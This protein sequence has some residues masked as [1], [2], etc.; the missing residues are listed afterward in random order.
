MS[1]LKQGQKPTYWRSLAELEDTPELREYV[2][3]EFATPLEELPPGSPGRRRFLQI[4]GASLALAGATG[5]RWQE[6]KLMPLSRRPEGRIPGEPERYATATELAGVAVGIVATSYEGRPIKLE[7]N[8]AHPANKGALGVLQQ[9]Q[10]LGVYDP[11]RSRH[12]MQK[13]QAKTWADF[14]NFA[15]AQFAAL[16]SKQGAGLRILLR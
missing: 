16:K 1:S 11:D 8:P 2:E 4:M 10:V 7:G 5:C 6:D 13:N 14:E 15:K 9:T 12:P 3:R